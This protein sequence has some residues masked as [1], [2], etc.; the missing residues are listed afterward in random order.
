MIPIAQLKGD[1]EFYNSL[2][3]LIE[4]LKLVAAAQY[5]SLEKRFKTYEVYLK[6]IEKIFHWL[7]TVNVE[8]PFIHSKNNIQAVI[9]V[10]TDAGL[11]GGLNAQVM[12]KAMKVAKREESKLVIIG[13]RGPLYVEKENMVFVNFPGIEDERRMEQAM[14]LRDYVVENFARNRIG[15]LIMVYPRPMS[16]TTQSIEVEE[17]LPF[18]LAEN[19]ET[20]AEVP[21]DV[22]FESKPGDVVEYL[23][24]LWLGQKIFDIFGL[25]RLAEQGAR[26]MHLENCTQ[27]LQD[28]QKS[29]KFQYF[30]VKHEIIDQNM[31]ELFAA[32]VAK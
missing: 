24:Y 3:S 22:I 4:V 10:T 21:D 29:L 17:L 8:S 13:K 15:K 32:R 18:S 30:R 23:V 19:K 20:S 16:F 1:I 7:D 6:S 27:R 2:G 26:Y 11:L 25:S 31:R 5:Q 28:M 9:A 14:K 12:D